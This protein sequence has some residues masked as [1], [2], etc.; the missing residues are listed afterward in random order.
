MISRHSLLITEIFAESVLSVGL[1]G[2][3]FIELTNVSDSTINLLNWKI[4]DGSSIVRI[5]TSFL[6]KPD[7]MA[8]ICASFLCDKLG[9]IRS[10]DWR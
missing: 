4:G 9:T 10:C 8:I 3:E 5:T 1:P 7:S 6:L 2:T